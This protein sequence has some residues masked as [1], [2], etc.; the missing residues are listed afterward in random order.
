MGFSER[1]YKVYIQASIFRP[2]TILPNDDQGRIIHG[3][4]KIS[5]I[6]EISGSMVINININEKSVILSSLP[7]MLLIKLKAT[8]GDGR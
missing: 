6:I 5:D 8:E 4:N 1:N 7:G 2:D 3:S